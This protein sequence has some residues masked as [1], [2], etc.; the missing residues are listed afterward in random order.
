M[1]IYREKLI[2]YPEI[3][4]TGY[5]VLP[6]IPIYRFLLKGHCASLCF[7]LVYIVNTLVLW[8]DA[9]EKSA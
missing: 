3:K 8:Y 4:H 1:G 9:F 2:L 7:A 6:G 5:T